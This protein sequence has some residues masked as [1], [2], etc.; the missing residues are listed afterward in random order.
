MMIVA[1]IVETNRHLPFLF[2]P[3]VEFHG[4]NE[5]LNI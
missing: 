3:N 4:H 1:G 5:D 2:G